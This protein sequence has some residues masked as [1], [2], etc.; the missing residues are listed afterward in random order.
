[1]RIAGSDEEKSLFGNTASGAKVLDSREEEAT[2]IKK[3]CVRVI[4][5]RISERM[6]GPIPYDRYQDFGYAVEVQ[7]CKQL[8]RSNVVWIGDLKKGACRHRA[9]LF[10]YLCDKLLPYLC[11]LERAK[12]E[13]GAHVGHAWNVVKFYGDNDQDGQQVR[14]Q[15]LRTNPAPRRI[16]LRRP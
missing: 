8:R 1:M 5:R 7:R 15:T 12:I 4:A 6:G 16:P 11:R 2:A 14:E 10:K 13:R 3:E 9:F